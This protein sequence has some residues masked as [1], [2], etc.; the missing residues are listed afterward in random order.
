M[1]EDGVELKFITCNIAGCG[2]MLREYEHLLR[3]DA[4]YLTRA[5]E[6]SKRVRDISE[7]LLELGLPPMTNRVDKTV[8]Y[9][10]ACHL[11]HAQKVS[12]APKSLLAL[13]PGLKMV[14]LAE[15]DMCCGAA[16][17]YNIQHPKMAAEL[18]DRKLR[19]IAASEAPTCVT[20]NVG[21]A[22][23]I[24]TQAAA[25]GQKLSV[26]HPVELVHQAVFGKRD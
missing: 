2:S 23:H 24:Q 15:A 26:V 14:P 1:P 19:N 10:E 8:T 16:G 3:D 22:M 21:C 7:V 9:H 18:A 11:V 20:G 4:K 5:R 6:F 12:S 25:R 13:I 17:T